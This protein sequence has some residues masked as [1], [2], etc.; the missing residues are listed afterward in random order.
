MFCTH[1]WK[2]R[3]FKH[4]HDGWS[5][6]QAYTLFSRLIHFMVHE[7]PLREKEAHAPPWMAKH[8]QW[9]RPLAQMLERNIQ[10]QSKHYYTWVEHISSN[11]VKISFW[12]KKAI[13]EHIYLKYSKSIASHSHFST[14]TTN[15]SQVA[16]ETQ[17]KHMEEA[18]HPKMQYDTNATWY[19]TRW[20][21]YHGL[22]I[23][24]SMYIHQRKTWYDTYGTKINPPRI[25]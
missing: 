12:F 21:S 15:I 6:F 8:S 13:S 23:K 5:I 25:N 1:V 9:Y 17:I 7:V 4:K 22:F 2:I 20:L 16:K 11:L 14:H 10:A 24:Q 3:H 18:H 19:I